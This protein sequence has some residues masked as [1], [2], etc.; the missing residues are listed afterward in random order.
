AMRPKI[1]TLRLALEG[2]F[3][4]HHAMLARMH[5]DHIDQLSAMEARL[6]KEVD[7]LMAPF[8]EAATRLLTIPGV[9]KRTAE[10]VISEIG[11]DMTRFPTANH[12]A[13]WAG[14]CPGND[15]SAGKRRSG[16]PTKGNE[17]LRSI[18]C[19]AAWAASHTKDTYLAA[20]YRRFLRRMGKRNE[21]KAIF[22]VAH[23]MLTVIWHILA[24][25]T[26]TYHDLGHD[27]FEKRNDTA[28]RQ[29][30]L[31]RELEKLGHRV[32]LEPAA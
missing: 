29:R 22:A 23:T 27:Y 18:L 17:A 5:L 11:V 28:A 32:S 25:D 24:S 19:E 7:K 9:G 16:R 31:V 21:S 12:L 3:G 15:E 6:D 20:Q 13:S 14:L 26:A 4:A 10:V 2:R 30:Y 8:A 1:P